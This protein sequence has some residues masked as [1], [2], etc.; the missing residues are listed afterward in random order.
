M[1]RK[2]YLTEIGNLLGDV[3]EAAAYILVHKPLL[4]TMVRILL[5]GGVTALTVTPLTLFL[6]KI[7]FDEALD[8]LSYPVG[9]A[10]IALAVCLY[11]VDRVVAKIEKPHLAAEPV[12]SFFNVSRKS[13]DR[14]DA[15][16]ENDRAF[17][18]CATVRLKAGRKPVKILK[19]DLFG[20]HRGIHLFQTTQSFFLGPERII[21]VD[22]NPKSHDER[23]NAQH[24][25]GSNYEICPPLA[26]ANDDF[27]A[28]SVERKFGPPLPGKGAPIDFVN[29]ELEMR[30]MFIV[31]GETRTQS[32]FYRSNYYANGLEP[33]FRISDVCYFSDRQFA[34]WRSRGAITEEEYA[35]LMQVHPEVRIRLME[36]DYE[37][38]RDA[39]EQWG[40]MPSTYDLMI[41]LRSAIDD[42]PV[43]DPDAIWKT[44]TGKVSR[45]FISRAKSYNFGQGGARSQPR[46]LSNS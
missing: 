2:A 10:L 21:G 11:A 42:L 38:S 27:V 17:S 26:I 5:V 20:F 16:Y 40:V 39:H 18:I 37:D 15:K 9:I 30:V 22:A 12:G 1:K 34:F 41:R 36:G 14:R 7:L 25:I 29:S 44:R 46:S 3:I 43:F 6:Y 4:K 8:A 31:D 33:I 23:V 19:V 35:A 24:R 28:F 13:D 32:F 45:W